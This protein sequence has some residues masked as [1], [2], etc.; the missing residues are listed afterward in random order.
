[1]EVTQVA[2]KHTER[3]IEDMGSSLLYCLDSVYDVVSPRR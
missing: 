1:M 3:N 2:K